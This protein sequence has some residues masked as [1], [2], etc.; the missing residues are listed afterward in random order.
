MNHRWLVASKEWAQHFVGVVTQ[1]DKE[2][3]IQFNF[4]YHWKKCSVSYDDVNAAEN[5]L[6]LLI[7]NSS[8]W[9]PHLTL[10]TVV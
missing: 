8:A 9:V 10:L 2:E 5:L 1:I 6:D 3:A 7:V 4:I